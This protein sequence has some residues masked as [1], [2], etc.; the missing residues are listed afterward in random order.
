MSES[1]SCPWPGPIPYSEEN[2]HLFFGRKSELDGLEEDICSDQYLTILTAPSGVGKSSLLNA[3]LLPRLRRNDTA[4]KGRNHLG[5]VLLL[6]NWVS[7]AELSVAGTLIRATEEE[8]ERLG[9]LY[10]IT[11]DEQLRRD[12]KRFKRAARSAACA[13]GREVDVAVEYFASLCDP[14]GK[15]VLIIDQAEELLGSSRGVRDREVEDEVLAI[16]G[17]LFKEEKRIRLVI[18]L[19]EEYYSRLTPL[20]RSVA[21]LNDRRRSIDPVSSD[22]A[23]EI[24]IKS[25]AAVKN[26]E[27]ESDAAL[28]ILDWASYERTRRQSPETPTSQ[29][30]D[31]LKMQALLRDVY[32]DLGGETSAVVRIKKAALVTFRKDRAKERMADD[33]LENYI[34]GRFKSIDSTSRPFRGAM[35][36]RCAA[37][38]A[39][40]LSSPGGL[41]VQVNE[42]D[43][44]WKSVCD[45]FS[46]LG[47]NVQDESTNRA[48]LQALKVVFDEEFKVDLDAKRAKAIEEGEPEDR[49]VDISDL[50]V[51]NDFSLLINFDLTGQP[52]VK[53]RVSGAARYEESNVWPLERVSAEIA[54]GAFRALH[55]LADERILK[56]LRMGD[57]R[58]AYELVHDG[59]GPALINWADS[60]KNGAV[61]ALLSIVGQRGEAFTWPKIDGDL[62]EEALGAR[63]EVVKGLS[64]VGCFINGVNIRGVTF[65]RCLF[66]GCVFSECTFTACKFIRCDFGGAVFYDSTWKNVTWESG[67]TGR[68]MLLKGMTWSE[69]KMISAELEGSMI[70]GL[71]LRG[72]S[73]FEDC[74]L[75]FF[76]VLAVSREARQHVLNFVDCDLLNGLL[77]GEDMFSVDSY[78]RDQRL[79][80]ERPKPRA[81]RRL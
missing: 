4:G 57:G 9:R 21:N 15:M 64:W 55:F 68:A 18:S 47:A 5:P 72:H 38:M 59:L 62:I 34:K 30:I 20:G 44:L 10:E 39:R 14:F 81:P 23:M 63:D 36:R 71:K 13:N 43:L 69:V 28:D 24:M 26:V 52:E 73:L 66:K 11:H 3:G 2:S 46:T 65:E 1:E 45:D 32:N 67:C 75:A 77:E 48:K 42:G 8:L 17:A 56:K 51:R 49:P 79:L 60:E 80:Y 53:E 29:I 31:L 16:V 35:L 22:V 58:Y 74:G 61:G 25:S 76:Q 41:K 12:I 33:A 19:R 54:I 78:S 40:W 70:T 27:L 50:P 7:S 6:N 37:H